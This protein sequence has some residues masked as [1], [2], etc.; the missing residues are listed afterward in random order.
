MGETTCPQAEIARMQ[1]SSEEEFLWSNIKAF[2]S[3]ERQKVHSS[4][5]KEIRLEPQCMIGYPRLCDKRDRSRMI[6]TVVSRLE[7]RGR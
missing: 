5:R 1:E 6:S 2:Q 3:D 7:V 4:K